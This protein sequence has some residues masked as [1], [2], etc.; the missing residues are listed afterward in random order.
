MTHHNKL[1]DPYED[2]ASIT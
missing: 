2:A 1:R